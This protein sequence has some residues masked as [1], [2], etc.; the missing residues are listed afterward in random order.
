MSFLDGISGRKVP[1]EPSSQSACTVE[2]MKAGTSF[3][4]LSGARSY[5]EQPVTVTGYGINGIY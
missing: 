5:G 2:L 4:V 3:M 1:S